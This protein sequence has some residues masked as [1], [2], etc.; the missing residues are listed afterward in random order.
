[1]LA[2]VLLAAQL[3]ALDQHIR[4][5]QYYLERK[6]AG[7]AVTEFEAA[8]NLKP[9]SAAARYNLGV[10]LRLWGDPQ[11]AEKTLREALRI[12]PR[13]PEAHF[14]LGL[15]LGDRVGSES[16]GLGEFE[17][18]VAQNPKF[19]DAHFNIGIIRWKR[20]EVELAIAAFRKGVEGRPESAE[21]RFRLGQALARAGKLAEARS[22]FEHAVRLD[23]ANDAAAYQLSLVYR[24]LGEEAKAADAAARVRRLREKASSVNRDQ[25]G[26][27]YRQGRTALEQG[28]LDQAV[29]H[30][31]EA[32]KNPFDEAQIRTMLGIALQ[33]K[34]NGNA[35][36]EFRKAL[37]I[38]PRSVDAHLNLGVLLM[39]AGDV[40][41]A[42]KEFRS[43]LEA[44][45]D[46]SEAH[47]N[48]GLACAVEQR[49]KEA[50]GSLRTAIRLN[51][52]NA[53]AH[54]NLGRVLRDSGDREA[55]RTS[56]ST[57]WKLDRGLTQAA[58][59]YGELLPRPQ[60]REVWREAFERDPLN[61]GLQKAF[62]S[63][64]DETAEIERVRRRFALLN[65]GQLRTALDALNRGSFAAA[66]EA[67]SKI[68]K[69]HPELNEVRRSRAL[70]LF[71]DHQYRAAVDEYE[72]L[73]RTNPGDAGLR[74]SL[75]MALREASLLDR[76]TA[77]LVEAV[78]LNP[79]SAQAHYQLGLVWQAKKDQTRA[80]EQFHEAR[81]IDP[82]LKP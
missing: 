32:L 34:G 28:Q 56:Y 66:S 5:G 1:M 11:G 52:A 63:A 21:F 47:F 46:F 25:S 67:L 75:G 50:A 72:T 58:L 40:A 10:A 35:A 36:A 53:H 6:D 4:L 74:L 24:K 39:R 54:W 62:L 57:A 80:M 71:A 8:V 3:S 73:A 59:E 20:D 26:L 23:P 18:A 29:A 81:R 27:L 76:A 7:R 70:A 78:R 2:L 43:A 64:L 9:D 13:F 65:D 16:S 51:P 12:Q 82:S 15:A 41:A 60:A 14:V 61:A 79:A 48:L 55:A 49:W 68:L 33:R 22:E 77:E 19:A 17:A 69:A 42:E 44:D 37:A 31:T 38:N 45:P 30:L